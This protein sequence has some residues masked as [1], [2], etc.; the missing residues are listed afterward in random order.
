MTLLKGGLNGANRQPSN[1]QKFN[2]EPSKKEKNYH[3]TSK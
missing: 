1:G 3:Q 2:R